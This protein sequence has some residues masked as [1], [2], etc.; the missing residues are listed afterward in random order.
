[1]AW[2]LEHSVTPAAPHVRVLVPVVRLV[3]LWR[4]QRAYEFLFYWGIPGALHSLLTPEFTGGRDGLLHYEY[5]FSHGG[6]LA[7]ALFL[8]L[9]YGMKPRQGSWWRIALLTQP[10]LLIIGFANWLLDANYMYLCQPP[11]ANNP[12]VIG[13]WPWYLIVL[14]IVGL[15]HLLIIYLPFG[16][17]YR[18]ERVVVSEIAAD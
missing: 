11:I 8:T 16:V 17:R 6:I 4:N 13:E 14:E 12:F 2:T 10:L 3:L 5:F 9:I 18:R 1:M 15:L 7:S